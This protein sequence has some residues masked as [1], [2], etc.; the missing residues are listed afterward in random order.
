M[1]TTSSSTFRLFKYLYWAGLLSVIG[2]TFAEPWL[3]LFSLLAGEDWTLPLLIASVTHVVVLAV[4]GGL[5]RREGKRALFVHAGEQVQ[6]AGYLHTLIGFGAA[7]LV[8]EPGSTTRPG[9]LQLTQVLHPIGSA[10]LTSILGWFLGGEIIGRESDDEIERASR[11]QLADLLNDLEAFTSEANERHAAYLDTLDEIVD[12]QEALRERQQKAL[13]DAS[14][15]GESVNES[16]SELDDTTQSVHQHLDA[17]STALDQ[18]LASEEFEESLQNIRT[19]AKSLHD[20]L[21]GV[22]EHAAAIDSHLSESQSS[23]KRVQENLDAFASEAPEVHKRYVR[24]LKEA[25]S[26]VEAVSD[27]V[28]DMLE[29]AR[30]D[31]EVLKETPELLAPIRKAAA[32]VSEALTQVEE[33]VDG[34]ESATN[35]VKHSLDAVN[36]SGAEVENALAETAS[37]AERMTR[38]VVQARQ[39]IDDMIQERYY[40]QN[41]SA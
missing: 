38:A 22:T 9:D 35:G 16:L 40:E 6:T 10:L 20:A 34:V 2:L 41:E 24:Q 36:K 1:L 27:A 13:E 26:S 4:V 31:A 21:S 29:K 12:S 11:D 30:E 39:I 8:F 19:E 3:G 25:R 7:L 14:E 32:G 18:S 23:A 33:S 37:T 5:L 28:T 17:I 15:L